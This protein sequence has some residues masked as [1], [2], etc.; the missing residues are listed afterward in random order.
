MGVKKLL[1]LLREPIS[2]EKRALLRDELVTIIRYAND[3]GVVP[4]LMTHGQVLLEHPDY[5]ERL[6]RH[7][8]VKPDR[9]RRPG[10][11]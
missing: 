4:M 1:S 11:P 7:R 3:A 5:L 2:A 9:R 8:R 6:V 10:S